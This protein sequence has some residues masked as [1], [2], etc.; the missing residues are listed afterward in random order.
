MIRRELRDDRCLGC[1]AAL[2]NVVGFQRENVVY[3]TGE[4]AGEPGVAVVALCCCGMTTIVPWSVS[5]KRAA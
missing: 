4:F 3:T 1:R 5:P 2:D